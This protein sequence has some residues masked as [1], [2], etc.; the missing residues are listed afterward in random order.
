MEAIRSPGLPAGAR[1]PGSRI[2]RWLSHRSAKPVGFVLALLPFA[3][4][5]WAAFADQ[6]GANPAEALI[7]SLGDWTIRFLVLVLVITPLRTVTGWVALARLRRMVGLFVF[8]YA[9]LHL[10]VYLVLDL[11]SYWA[12][13]LEDIVQRPYITVGFS[14]WLL[15]LALA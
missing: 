6:L 12:Q 5:V 7:R 1:S 2:N 4:L 3:W 15:L 8:F 11:G 13:L 14:A 9:C 10:G